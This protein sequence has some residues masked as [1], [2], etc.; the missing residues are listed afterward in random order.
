MLRLSREADY[1]LLALTYMAARPEGQLSYRREIAAHYNIPREFLAK[2]LQKMTRSGLIRSFR[3]TRGGY[4]LARD[5]SGITLADV[6]EAMDGPMALVVCQRGDACRCVQEEACT[7]Q[8]ALMEVRQEIRRVLSAV[9]L[10][11]LR[12][13]MERGASVQGTVTLG[14]M[15]R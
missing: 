15:R 9:T 10:G 14:A 8:E 3:G 4:T 6:V 5:V 13:R 1:G 7:V 11:D 12:R 2:V